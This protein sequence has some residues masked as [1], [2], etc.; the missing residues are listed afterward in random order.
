MTV[1]WTVFISVL[2]LYFLEL[3]LVCFCFE[4]LVLRTGQMFCRIYLSWDW[5]VFLTV[6]L[7][8]WFLGGRPQRWSIILSSHCIKGRYCQCDLPLI[9]LI[10]ITWLRQS[11]PGFSTVKLLSSLFSYCTLWKQVTK[12][13]PHVRGRVEYYLE[14]FSVGI[15]S[16]PPNSLHNYICIKDPWTHGSF[17]NF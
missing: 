6:S 17:E 7:W 10:S 16:S 14:C 5:S 13:S 11:L 15:L 2:S 9:V 3:F 1:S 12:Y 4:F 8:L